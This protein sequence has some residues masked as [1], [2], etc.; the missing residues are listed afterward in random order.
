MREIESG[1]VVE[2]E[3]RLAR[4][5]GTFDRL[6]FAVRVL[7]LLR[8]P[9]LTIVVRD[10]SWGLRVDQGHHWHRPEG[11]RWAELAIPPQAPPEDIVQAIA[12]L[13]GVEQDP[14]VMDALYALDPY[15]TA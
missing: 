6:R 2:Q 4:A 14:R 7:D 8:I 1:Y 3:R 10:G 9:G 15:E 5:R 11:W 13:A 12:E